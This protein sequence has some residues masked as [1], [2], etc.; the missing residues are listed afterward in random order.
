MDNCHVGVINIKCSLVF[1]IEGP[2][3]CRVMD[4]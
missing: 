2:R 1:M 3:F 4:F